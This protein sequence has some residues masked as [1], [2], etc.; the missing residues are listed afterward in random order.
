MKCPKSLTGEAAEF[1][2][3]VAPDLCSS[4]ILTP[5]DKFAF[6]LL[7]QQWQLYCTAV[8]DGSRPS[9]VG[10]I[11]A[12]VRQGFKAFGLD[13]L[14]RTKLGVTISPKTIDEY[15]IPQ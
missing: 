15:G 9:V 10:E 1:W 7:C 2:R 11:A 5:T 8:R 4:G 14:S 12:N 3:E 6:V 13:P